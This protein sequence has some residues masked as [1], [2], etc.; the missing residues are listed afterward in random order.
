MPLPKS[1]RRLFLV[2]RANLTGLPADADGR[3]PLDLFAE[4]YAD[5]HRS[6]VPLPDAMTLATCDR[7]GRP[8]ARMVLLKSFDEAGFVLFT[9]FSSRKAAELDANPQAALVWYW[10]RLYRQVRVEGEVTRCSP[11]E[12]ATY[13]ATR[14]RGSQIG[15]WASRQSASL[16]DRDELVARFEAARTRFSGQDV[17]VPEFWGGYRLKP[18]RIEFWQ[19]RANRLHDRLCFERQNGHWQTSWLYP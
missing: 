10:H 7:D 9:N 3:D 1:L 8:A 15:A 18:R 5:A 11:Q 16:A 6:G 12:A 4:W 14:P 2:G 19:G 17:P 13:F